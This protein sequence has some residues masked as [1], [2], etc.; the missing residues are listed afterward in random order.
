MYLTANQSHGV[1][2]D[3]SQSRSIISISVLKLIEGE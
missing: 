3:P 2:K 1:A